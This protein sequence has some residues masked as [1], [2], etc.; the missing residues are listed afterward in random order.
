MEH[1]L[2]KNIVINPAVCNGKPI[3]KGTRITVKTIMEFVLA[4][5]TD[6]DILENYP[7]I[8]QDDLKTCKE[9][10]LIALDKG[11]FSIIPTAA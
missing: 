10:S 4:G 5:D 3:I 2:Y 8:T 7:T 9:F 1:V 11:V 6:K